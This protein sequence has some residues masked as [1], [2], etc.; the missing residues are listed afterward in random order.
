MS[1]SSTPLNYSGTPQKAGGSCCRIM[2]T[3]AGCAERMGI[4]LVRV[5]VGV[6]FIFHG[7]Q[8]WFVMGPAKMM[9][10]FGSMGISHSA[11]Y[12]AMTAEL[13]CGILLVLGLF[14]R[15]AAVPILITM[16]VAIVKVHLAHGFSLGNGGYEY[17]LTLGVAALALILA[18]PG[19][20][21]VD[22]LFTGKRK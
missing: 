4:T 5:M 7:Y 11:T 14:T 10:M 17:P 12:A 19:T 18:G 22:N 16:I 20:L 15:F 3:S 2:A 9:E 1:E 21:A 6:V 8:K 13:G